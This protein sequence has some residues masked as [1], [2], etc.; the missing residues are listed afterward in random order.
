MKCVTFYVQAAEGSLFWEERVT[1]SPSSRQWKLVENVYSKVFPFM[2]KK[3]WKIWKYKKGSKIALPGKRQRELTSWLCRC[4]QFMNVYQ[5]LCFFSLPFM[6]KHYAL[7]D[8]IAVC[9]FA[10][11]CTDVWTVSCLP[12]L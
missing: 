2:V 7:Y 3:I 12:L 1:K 4:L 11:L 6:A 9:L 8:H 10:L 5:D